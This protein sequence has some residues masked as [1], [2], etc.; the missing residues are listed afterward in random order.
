MATITLR[1]NGDNGVGSGWANEASATSNLWQS[2]DEIDVHSPNTS[3]YAGSGTSNSTY[4]ITFDNCPSNVDTVTQCV[5]RLVTAK[6]ST[7]GDNHYIN[8]CQLF[9]SDKT[10]AIDTDLVG[11]ISSTTTPTLSSF[12]RSSLIYGDKTS[13]DGVN[14]VLRI[15]SAS[16]GGS[17]RVYAVQLDLTYDETASGEEYQASGGI[18]LGGSS[19][20]KLNLKA[21]GSGEIVLGG[22]SNVNSNSQFSFNSTGGI[23]L[24][25][26]SSFA[27]GFQFHSNGGVI[28]GGTSEFKVEQIQGIGGAC[29]GG[30]NKLIN[31][32][33]CSGTNIVIP[34]DSIFKMAQDV[35]L[36]IFDHEENLE[37]HLYTAAE[38]TIETESD[39]TSWQMFTKGLDDFFVSFGIDAGTV[40][41]EGGVSHEYAIQ[42]DEEEWG[43]EVHILGYAVVG[44]TTRNLYWA[45]HH[46][47]RII[48]ATNSSLFNLRLPFRKQGEDE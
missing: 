19:A 37:I 47:L 14:L 21:T 12:T 33:P 20:C 32:I 15:N 48:S 39:F 34:T 29:V 10:T 3:D 36:K 9:K 11:G 38:E 46:G 22:S 7:K 1:P 6:T 27:V 26:S 31:V 25:G 30:T 13:W 44:E 18:V 16:G 28:L 41:L 43:E 40:F 5:V 2:I 4:W 23:V 42:W 8:S 17:G 45:N 24:S 35:I